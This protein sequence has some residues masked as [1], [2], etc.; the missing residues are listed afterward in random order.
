LRRYQVCIRSRFPR[1]VLRLDH[2]AIDLSVEA[3]VQLDGLQDGRAVLTRGDDGDFE[4]VAAEVMD[5]LNASRV[6]L[7][8]LVFNGLVGQVVLAVPE[9]AY[10]FELW[11]VVRV[12]LGELDAAGCE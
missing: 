6:R 5:E 8:P 10:R 4:S 2:V 3:A 12:S 1:Q 11:G 9:P 7:H